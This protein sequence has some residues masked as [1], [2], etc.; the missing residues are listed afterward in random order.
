MNKNNIPSNTFVKL[1]HLFNISKE[2]IDLFLEIDR[3]G[4]PTSQYSVDRFE[5]VK[6]LSWTK[7]KVE[8]HIKELHLAGFIIPHQVFKAGGT[9]VSI[10]SMDKIV[11][12]IEEKI[13]K[14][15]KIKSLLTK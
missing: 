5:L 7:A 3:L 12:I 4:T 15:D 1:L 2:G 8:K 11:Q 13:G 6:S 14:L 10:Q 9:I